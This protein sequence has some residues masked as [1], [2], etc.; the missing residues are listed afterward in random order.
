AAKTLRRRS[1]ESEAAIPAGLRPAGSL[2][3]IVTDLGISNDS[4]RTIPA[5]AWIFL[6]ERLDRLRLL[7]LVVGLTGIAVLA[8]PVFTGG[9]NPLGILFPMIAAVSWAAGSVYQKSHPIEADRVTMTG[10][11]LLLASAI[12]AVGFAVSGEILPTQLSP[13]VAWAIAY[14]VIGA[15]AMAYWLW[16]TLLNRVSVG[17][18]S[19]TTFAIPVVGVIGAMVLVGERPSLADYAGFAAVIAAAGIAMWAARPKPG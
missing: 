14:H 19:L 6:G 2:N 16:F 4:A 5:L 11:Q 15:T 1:N 13:R 7:A 8:A 18:A 12:S 9:I 3:Q 10:Y 17:A